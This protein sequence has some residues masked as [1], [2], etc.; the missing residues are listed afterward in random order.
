MASHERVHSRRADQPL[1]AANTANSLPP[2]PIMT[3]S[4]SATLAQV[5]ASQPRSEFPLHSAGLTE[6]LPQSVLNAKQVP[7]NPEFLFPS[8]EPTLPLLS[9]TASSQVPLSEPLLVQPGKTD[10]IASTIAAYNVDAFQ[11][12]SRRPPTHPRNHMSTST[13]LRHTPNSHFNSGPPANFDENLISQENIALQS[14]E[15]SFHDDDT[16]PN[17]FCTQPL[18]GQSKPP[19]HKF[20][21]N[22]HFERRIPLPSS[23]PQHVV[24]SSQ[25]SQTCPEP[26]QSQLQ[27]QQYLSQQMYQYQVPSKFGQMQQQRLNHHH[28]SR[29]LA[30]MQQQQMSQKR[31]GLTIS[32]KQQ[33][34]QKPHTQQAQQERRP[35]HASKADHLNAKLDHTDDLNHIEQP[36]AYTHSNHTKTLDP[37][38]A[39]FSERRTMPSIQPDLSGFN[40]PEA[41]PTKYTE[42]SLNEQ[43]QQRQQSEFVLK[44][45]PSDWNAV[46][47]RPGFKIAR[48]DK[49]VRSDESADFAQT[50]TLNGI[51]PQRSHA[52]EFSRPVTLRGFLQ[53]Q[54]GQTNILADTLKSRRD[55]PRSTS[56]VVN[57]SNEMGPGHAIQSDM[58]K[59]INSKDPSG[60][61]EHNY[62]QHTYVDGGSIG[63]GEPHESGD[64]E[65]IVEDEA[66]EAEPEELEE[67]RTKGVRSHVAKYGL[68]VPDRRTIS[69]DIINVSNDTSKWKTESTKV[70]EDGGQWKE[71]RLSDC[72]SQM[73]SQEL[74]GYFFA[75]AK[76]SSTTGGSKMSIGSSYSE[77]QRE[78]SGQL[79]TQ[80]PSAALNRLSG[81]DFRYNGMGRWSGNMS[82][83]YDS[84][85]S[86]GA[87]ASLMS[88]ETG[89]IRGVYSNSVSPLGM[90]IS[91]PS[92]SPYPGTAFVHRGFLT[93]PRDYRDRVGT[94]SKNPTLH[95][96][97]KFFTNV[98]GYT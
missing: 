57:L 58:S 1:S 41:P 3:S 79:V 77:G 61:N 40:Q 72:I 24:Q 85:S 26:H 50:K 92:A 93:S 51:E 37:I 52:D 64:V 68:K 39:R 14:Q 47:H 12:S 87:L 70:S 5:I 2:N 80:K 45:A 13:A 28:D 82:D 62:A 7:E 91:T 94:Q 23:Q 95:G 66:E 19:Q 44:S 30:E 73:L 65:F 9:R 25:A 20:Y 8:H 75:K 31:S 86:A 17:D 83:I 56:D 34:S 18:L 89:A 36:L 67:M 6:A 63:E 16:A 43:K 69:S 15:G 55:Q 35:Y 48:E 38:K 96:L 88:P 33:A 22:S 78:G 97:E 10:D 42:M 27:Q 98:D 49:N 11:D 74:I 53:A 29:N 54:S 60:Q 4:E 59:D 21:N 71:N 76:S 84:S 90:T 46:D 81:G 32:Q